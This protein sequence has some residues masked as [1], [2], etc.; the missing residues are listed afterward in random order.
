MIQ[1]NSI[2]RSIQ[3][4][5]SCN[6]RCAHTE[7]YPIYKRNKRRNT[8]LFRIYFQYCFSLY[9][10]VVFIVKCIL[11]QRFFSLRSYPTNK[12]QEKIIKKDD[13]RHKESNNRTLRIFPINQANVCIVLWIVLYLHLQLTA[14]NDVLIYD[15]YFASSN[16]A[17]SSC[18]CQL[19][20][21]HI[22][23]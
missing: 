3:D 19:M 10:Y 18:F 17:A 23:K 15:V 4:H 8:Q 6:P 5:F 1:S 9:R 20:V 14:S 21:F 13:L 22:H 12:W 7:L 2:Y 16:S 11:H